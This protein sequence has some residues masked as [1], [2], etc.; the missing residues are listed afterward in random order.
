MG[1]NQRIGVLLGGM[2]GQ[3]EIS[4]KAGE[5]ILAVL[6]DV[7]HDARPV[8]V[9]RDIDLVLRQAKI[10]VAFLALRGRY[11]G[12]GCVQGLLEV[13]GIPYTGPGHLA[14]GLAMNKAKTAEL[15]RL[16][17][18]PTAPAYV[19]RIDAATS[20]LESHGAF[21]FPVIVRPVGAGPGL[22]LSVAADE[23]E[24]EAAVDEAFRFDDEALVERFGEGRIVS[25]GVL[26]G[27]ALGAIELG[28]AGAYASRPGDASDRAPAGGRGRLSVARHRA[29]LRVAAQ[30]YE[31]LG[32]EGPALVDLVVTERA[33]EVILDIDAAPPLAPCGT[34]ARIAHK[35]G[36]PFQE[37]VVSILR[38]AR[39]RAH[40]RR[41]ERRGTQLA[42][43]G[44]ERRAGLVTSAH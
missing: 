32:L 26:D 28:A 3:R 16:H 37:L 30:A 25:V 41:R 4:M 10:D 27:A 42:F 19:R 9:D 6:A 20:L 18:L 22:G 39:L 11:G 7:G 5:A 31:A 29:L 36:L 34:F 14:A 35:A 17:N 24:L 40:G 23:I 13:L 44:P 43:V 12:D 1:A 33:N 21:G 8:F 38:A 15:L 2:S